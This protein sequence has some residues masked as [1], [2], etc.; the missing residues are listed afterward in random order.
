MTWL[1]EWRVTVGDDV[2]TNVT[3]VSYATGRLDIDRQSTAG[4]C[5]VEIINDNNAPFTINVTEPITLELK[6][7]SGTYVTV[8]GGEVSD[9]NIGVRSPEDVGFI[10]SGTILGIGSLARLTKAIFNTAL[11]EDLDGEQIAEILG[12]ALNLSWAEVTPTVTWATY[13]ATVTWEEA[14]SYLGTVDPG[15]YTMINLAASETEKSQSLVDQIANSALGQIFETKDGLVSYDNADHRSDYLAA[16]GYTQF[17]ASFATPTSIRSTTQ[18]ARIRNSLIYK[19]GAGYATTYSD[20]DTD[21]IASYGLF[22]RSQNSNIKNLADITA[23]ATRDLTLRKT[24]RGSLEV[25]TFRLDNPDMSN[26]L[27]NDLIDVF[28]GEPVSVTNLP[29]N[30]LGGSFDGFVENVVMKATPTYVDLTLYISAADFSLPLNLGNYTLEQTLT[31]DG[32]F[33]VPSGTNQI[34]VLIKAKGGDGQNGANAAGNGGQGGTGGGGGGAGAFWNFNVIPATDYSVTFNTG[35][36]NRVSFDSLMSISAGIDGSAGGSSGGLFSVDP[37]VI[38]YDA[39]TG[40]PAGVGGAVKTTDGNGNAGSNSFGIGS[41]VATPANVGL[42]PIRAGG[43]GGGGGSGARDATGIGFNQGGFGGT[44][45]A[46]D[47]NN[48]GG[49][50][51][52]AFEDFNVNGSAGG[53]G[54]LGN[55]GGGGGGG[56]FQLGF[57]SGTGGTGSAGTGAVVYIYTR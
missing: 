4:Y 46:V 55:G 11:A 18:I 48:G 51:G 40:T 53:S 24:P 32:T 20:S 43:G 9:F 56:A 19:Y 26:A 14:E 57:G 8:F 5:R 22:E 37:S 33:T 50:G 23:I 29:S 35:S 16:Y 7:S 31:A 34:A 45:G 30:L 47:G 54:V 28:F 25:I 38:Y 6:N 49:N 15:I 3:S 13:P 44:G 1:P 27:R 36:N 41:L 2:Y 21:S 10:T 12:A 52:D 39:K 42:T 17:D